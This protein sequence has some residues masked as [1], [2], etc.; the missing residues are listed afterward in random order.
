MYDSA[1][2]SSLEYCF[3]VSTGP[4][5]SQQALRL[6]EE[7]RNE[8]RLLEETVS[9]LKEQANMYEQELEQVRA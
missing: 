4:L 6:L 8:N 5:L 3:I 2:E 7:A 1:R 9:S